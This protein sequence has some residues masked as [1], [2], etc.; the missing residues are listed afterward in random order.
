VILRILGEGQYELPDSD[1]ERL[2]E[3]DNKAVAEVEAGNEPAFRDI[4]NQ[5]LALV[6][7]DGTKLD[8][9]ELVASEVIMP[10]RDV[11][12]AEAQAEFT[13]DGLIPELM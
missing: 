11:S 1:A 13:G 5:M 7:S 10:P 6:E 3:L 12:F 2:N 4:W 8:D 9:D